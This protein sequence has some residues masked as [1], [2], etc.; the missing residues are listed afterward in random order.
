MKP[1]ITFGLLAFMLASCGSGSSSSSSSINEPSYEE[2]K[3][4]L[5]DQEKSDPVRFLSV[6]NG[7]YRKTLFGGKMELEGQIHNAATVATF[8][9]AV[10]HVRF[11]SET[12][13]E[14]GTGDY[15]IYEFFPPNNSK[16]FK[17]KIEIPDGTNSV[18]FEVISAIAK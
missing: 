11:N 13:T 6:E 16:P 5:E 14:I 17:F 4:S 10:L 15:T 12:Q 8:K 7:T 3:M 9:D 18:G 1:I 2:Q